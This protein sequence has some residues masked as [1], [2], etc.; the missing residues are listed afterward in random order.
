MRPQLEKLTFDSS[1]SF[2]ARRFKRPYFDAPWHYHPE[3]EL[4]YIVSGNGQR[5]VADS[6]QPFTEGDLVLLGSYLPHFWRNDPEFYAPDSRLS[7]ESVV[8]QFPQALADDFLTKVP[9]FKNILSLLKQSIFG[10]RFSRQTT[11]RVKDKLLQLP[12]SSEGFRL[13]TFL[14]ILM[15]LSQ[16][17]SP[18]LLASTSYRITIDDAETERMK[19]ILDFTLTHFQEEI[20]LET[21][22]ETAHLTVPAFCRYFKK[23]TQKTYVEFLNHLRIN[24]ARKLLTDS[25]LSIAQ[26]GL[27]CGFRN[28]SNF[29]QLFKRQTGLSPLQ[30]KKAA[31]K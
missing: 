13:L 8:I 22:A 15:H 24:H 9:D 18:E 20:H 23:R 7:A 30:Y 14:D 4:T 27:E 17:T 3:F 29:H 10:I 6:I 2:L 25:E 16:D 5:F 26:V 11:D 19:R 1:S 28:L 31:S 12:F 21:I